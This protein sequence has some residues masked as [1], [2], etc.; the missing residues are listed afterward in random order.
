ML[1]FIDQSRT[2]H[3]DEAFIDD[4]LSL[5]ILPR[6]KQLMESDADGAIKVLSFFFFFF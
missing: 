4:I 2:G 5:D 6:I 3:S 1:Y